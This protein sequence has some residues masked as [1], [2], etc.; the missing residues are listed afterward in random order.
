MKMIDLF[1]QIV[2]NNVFFSLV[3][4]LIAA[5]VGIIFKRPFLTHLLWLLV[6]VKLLT[7]PFLMIPIDQNMWIGET[8]P[9]INLDIVEQRSVRIVQDNGSHEIINSPSKIVSVGQ[10][11]GKHWLIFAW[12]SGS[13]IALI[14]SIRQVFRF[15][16][17]L[18]KESETGSPDIQSAAM[19]IAA[20]LGL[21]TAPTI[22]TTSANISPM[23]W[24]VGG[25]VWVVMP[26]ALINQMNETQLQWILSHELAHVRRRDYMI[27]W[28]EWFVCVCFWW[29]PV[30][31][32]ARYNLRANEELCCD[33]LVL[34]SMK[35]KP[36]S[37][38]DSLLKAIEFLNCPAP[39]Q[40][41]LT[42]ASGINSGGL[43]NNRIKMIVSN[44]LNRSRL[45]WLRVCIMLGALI[46]L[47][48]GL[49]NAQDSLK[50]GSNTSEVYEKS[51][52]LN[53]FKTKY[54]DINYIIEDDL[55][56]FLTK[57]SWGTSPN[58]KDGDYKIMLKDHIDR[59]IESVRTVLKMYPEDDQLVKI[60]LCKSSEDVQKKFYDIYGIHVN[61]IA[62][63][64]P[65]VDSI[66]LSLENLGPRVIAH[67][68]GH[69]TAEKYFTDS[70]Q[71]KIHE[72]LAQYAEMHF[73]D[74][75]RNNE[76]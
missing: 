61:Y 15:H 16:R 48:L 54:A 43:L 75:F 65:T 11:H 25:K 67:E 8:H 34:F 32:W 36:Y 7:P 21:K 39:A 50:K 26:T 1:F 38:G 57:I 49:T 70:A 46:V 14:W 72:M 31:W 3:L 35:P 12:L 29:N 42:I 24:W 19:K 37:Y 52:D 58:K 56:K 71:M 23:V 20:C 66:F 5:T 51:Y 69:L 76:S 28:I 9:I 41:P 62:F 18:K 22:H 6:F 40:Q 55:Y 68:I 64:S 30:T 27:R 45:R 10:I 74:A 13:I 17:L 47:P 33:A 63:Y 2:L 4:A 53:H 59:M 60:V 44:D 73:K